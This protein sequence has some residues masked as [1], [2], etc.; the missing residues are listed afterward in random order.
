MDYIKYS[1]NVNT[2]NRSWIPHYE[3][4]VL[5]KLKKGAYY[6]DCEKLFPFAIPRQRLTAQRNE[7]MTVNDYKS[8]LTGVWCVLN[9]LYAESIGGNL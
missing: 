6:G 8:I 2:G 7:P 3:F 9:T 4:L 5:A 1:S